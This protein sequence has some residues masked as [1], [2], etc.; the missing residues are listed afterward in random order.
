MLTHFINNGTAIANELLTLT[1]KVGIRQ[2]DLD[3]D[4]EYMRNVADYMMK[5]FNIQLI[6]LPDEEGFLE[7]SKE[8][9]DLF[10]IK[11]KDGKYFAKLKG[12]VDSA[13]LRKYFRGNISYELLK[14]FVATEEKL[15]E[16]VADNSCSMGV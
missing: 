15:I 10:E 2:I 8:N 7:W 14:A 12:G 9:H 6:V 1:E 3:I 13:V 5:N 11:Q 4:E 16:F